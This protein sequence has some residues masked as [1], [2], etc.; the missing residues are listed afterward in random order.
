MDMT[1]QTALGTP[2]CAP[3]T[4]LRL[5][6]D[7]ETTGTDPRKDR[8]VELAAVRFDALSGAVVDRFQA[9]VNP[10]IEV[11]QDAV[12]I[13]GLTTEFLADKPSFKEV[14]AE[15]LAF[16]AGAQGVA[17]NA[18]FDARFLEAELKRAKAPKLLA[19]LADLEDT[20]AL[21]RLVVRSRKHSLDVLCD[22]YGVARDQRTAH[23]ALLDCELLAAVYPHLKQAHAVLST[24]LSALTTLPIGTE[25]P[26]EVSDCVAHILELKALVAFLE[27]EVDRISV[28][29]KSVLA[30]QSQAGDGWEISFTSVAPTDWKKLV[31]DNLAGALKDVNLDDYKGKETQR[32]AIKHTD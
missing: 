28:P 21:S 30:G 3:A 16:C 17:H 20:L 12:A 15:F 29:L 8:I 13:H 19:T 10:G 2:A 1:H 6:L 14:A 25:I 24:G 9:Y 27:K 18:P 5:A 4:T 7:T 22:R 26:E 32:M 11:P 31:E 23:G